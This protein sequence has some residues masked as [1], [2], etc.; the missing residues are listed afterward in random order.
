M[1]AHAGL[2]IAA[3]HYGS[4]SAA[5]RRAVWQGLNAYWQFTRPHTVIGTTLSIC[6]VAAIAVVR[7]DAAADPGLGTAVYG[8]NL[9]SIF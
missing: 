4:E 2:A 8:S 5:R 1:Y 6:V 3:V 7:T 9:A